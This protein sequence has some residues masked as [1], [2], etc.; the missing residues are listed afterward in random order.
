MFS[1][2]PRIYQISCT[3][4]I[5]L[6]LS[7]VVPGVGG[8]VSQAK[9][10]GATPTGQPELFKETGHILAYNFQQTWHQKGGLAVFGLPLTEVFME[11]GRPVQYFERAV[12]E[13]HADLTLVQIGLLGSEISRNRLTEAPFRPAVQASPKDG[14]YFV[15]TGHNLSHGFLEFWLN[16]GGLSVF[17]F[18]ISEEFREKNLQDGHTYIVQYFERARFEYH[19]DEPSAAQVLLGQL[20]RAYLEQHKNAPTW[21]VS[22]VDTAAAAWKALRPS[23]VRIPRLG[24]DTDVVEGGLN[25]EGWDVPRYTAVHYWPVAAFPGSRGNIIVAG[26]A[27]YKNTIFDQLPQVAVGDEVIITVNAAERR[28]RVN[29]LQI[30]EPW[31]NWVLRPTDLETLT[32][33]TCVPPGLYNQRLIVTALPIKESATATP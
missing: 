1:S 3:L 18:P 5:W 22:P 14:Y 28:Y 2:R 15:E 17:G 31:D 27:G 9:A 23:R 11:N 13:W 33:I 4:V 29:G 19:P 16:Q 25:L 26:H 7:F 8:F 24:L 30:V 6:T 21:A 20:G 32:L 10:D 12:L